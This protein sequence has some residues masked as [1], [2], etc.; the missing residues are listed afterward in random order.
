[1]TPALRPGPRA[2]LAAACAALALSACG[3]RQ[4][5]ARPAADAGTTAASPA[6]AAPTLA[7]GL[8]VCFRAIAAHL[9]AATR[10]LD[11]TSSFESGSDAARAPLH[12]CTVDYQSP[13][14]PRSLV[15]IRLDPA[16]GRFSDPYA[17]EPA[18]GGNAADMRLD[19]QLVALS[20]VDASPLAAL[21]ASL[22]PQLDGV[23][24][25]YAWTGLRLQAPG[26][27]H[28]AHTLRLDIEGRVAASGASH[29]GY[30]SVSLDG[31]TVLR[32]HLLP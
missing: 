19:A 5:P 9:P 21:V 23:Y 13:E 1:M 22:A 15:G 24:S 2:L 14:D 30:A 16:T 17:I 3:G 10:V 32:N 20:Q 18:L 6:A 12:L 4:A 25:R 7:D 26:A 27:F 28:D 8:D 11:I 29:S 31:A